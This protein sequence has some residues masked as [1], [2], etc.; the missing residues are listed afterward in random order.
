MKWFPVLFV[1]SSVALGQRP[2]SRSVYVFPMAA[3][4][5]QYLASQITQDHVM[6]VVADPKLA[7]TVLTDRLGEAFEQSLAKL[8]PRD[9]DPDDSEAPHHSFRSSGTKGTVFLVD[10][11]S[12]EV[13]WSDYEKPARTVSGKS[14]NRRAERLAKKLQAMAGK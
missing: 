4:L 14:L 9:E 1:L 13:I 2:V 3:G 11:K 10:A 5:D 6:Q 12:R 8:H 7:D